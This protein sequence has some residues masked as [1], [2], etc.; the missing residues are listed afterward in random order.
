MEKIIYEIR[1]YVFM[2]GGVSATIAHIDSLM[3]AS[4]I[5]LMASSA[6]ILW[7]RKKYRAWLAT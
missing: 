2:S 7:N 3:L 1:P 6:Y 5:L 4:G